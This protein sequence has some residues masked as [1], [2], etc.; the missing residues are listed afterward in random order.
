MERLKAIGEVLENLGIKLTWALV[1]KIIAKIAEGRTPTEALFYAI[2]SAHND[3][4][5]KMLGV[6]STEADRYAD[7]FA[8]AIG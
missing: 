5:E 2:L 7:A 1:V 6:P 4:V 8:Q 3:D